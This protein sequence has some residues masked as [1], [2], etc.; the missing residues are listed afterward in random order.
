MTRQENPKTTKDPS[1]GDTNLS[2]GIEME[3][4]RTRSHLTIMVNNI[5]SHW[6]VADLKTFLGGFGNIVK[7]E[8]FED[9]DVAVLSFFQHTNCRLEKVMDMER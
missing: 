1:E 2:D 3:E 5:P 7:L 9:R 6:M 8:I 4:W